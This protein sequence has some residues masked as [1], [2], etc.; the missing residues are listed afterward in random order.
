MLAF[1]EFAA[2]EITALF[3]A[4]AGGGDIH[5]IGSLRNRPA[6]SPADWLSNVLFHS[7]FD[8]Y[9]VAVGPTTVTVNHASVAGASTAVVNFWGG[10]G[11]VVRTGQIGTTH[12]DLVTHGLGY[13]PKY[14]VISGGHIIAPGTMIQS[15][16]AQERTVTPYATS[17][18]IRLMDIGISSGSALAA[19]SRDYTVVVFRAPATDGDL[20]FDFDTSDGRLILSKDK[21]D[22]A[23]KMLR[24][25]GAGD[26]PFDISK[27]P[28]VGIRNGVAKTVLADGTTVT[29]S[30]YSGSFTGSPSIQC[31]VD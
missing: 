20:L 2:A 1:R 10:T 16:T 18:K 30:G 12:D 29:E 31:A 17:T 27:G 28:T 24:K 7:N 22:S 3:I 6:A 26:S 21:F 13:V 4:A 19:T 25:A 23:R 8:N 9:Q 15:A 5:D 14:M 11:Q